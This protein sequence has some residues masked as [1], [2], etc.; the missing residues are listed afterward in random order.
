MKTLRTD[1]FVAALVIVCSV[2]MLVALTIAISGTHLT[3]PKATLTIDL[4]SAVGLDKQAEVRYAGANV[5]RIRAV[6]PLTDEEREKVSPECAIRVI[7]DIHRHLPQLR[8][9][10][11][12][13]ITADTVLGEKYL[14]LEPGPVTNPGLAPGTILYA[15]RSASLDEV[16]TAGKILLDKANDL[17]AQN[18]EAIDKVIKDL[19][20]VLDNF[21]VISTYGKTFMATVARK[22]HRLIFGG[23]VPRLPSEEKIISTD[24]PVP[25][26]VP[27]D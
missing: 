10:T 9:G 5:G 23:P 15:K 11:T 12:A 19:R 27:K 13:S 26:P 7:A 1:F 21:K 8:V 2:V 4:P 24:Q 22:P 25:A 6:R 14:N 16:M 18:R 20:V 17:I 3:A